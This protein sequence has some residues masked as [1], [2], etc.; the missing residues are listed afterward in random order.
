MLQATT[1][2]T[3]TSTKPASLIN[4]LRDSG[5]IKHYT[6]QDVHLKSGR[7]SNM[8]IDM[9][10]AFSSPQIVKTVCL[11]ME[12]LL[13]NYAIRARIPIQKLHLVGVPTAGVGWAKDLATHM[14]LPFKYVRKEAKSHGLRKLIEGGDIVVKD[15]EA[16]VL[17][18]DVCT[19]GTSVLEYVKLLRE[20][21]IPVAQVL[22]IADRGGL[23]NIREFVPTAESVLG[24]RDLFCGSP[25]DLLREIT[26][27]KQTKLIFSADITDPAELLSMVQKVAPSICA[28]KLHSDIVHNFN[29]TFIRELLALRD[30]HYFAIIEDAK[31]ADIASVTRTKFL[32]APQNPSGWA[33]FVTIHATS[34]LD[35][36]RAIIDLK[37]SGIIVISEMSTSAN[38]INENY[39]AAVY[40]MC[41]P[42][43]DSGYFGGFVAQG[44][45][46]PFSDFPRN[47]RSWHFFTPG[48]KLDQP[49]SS[50]SSGNSDSSSREGQNHRDPSKVG[51]DYHI[52]GR[53]IYLAQ[54]PSSE[55]MRYATM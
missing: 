27:M 26:E 28:L 51:T 24:F 11:E 55:A 43:Q 39:T 18:E 44:I 13:I 50:G 3:T 20:Y 15:G 14:R 47:G 40:E 8:Y 12:T 34:G 22:C 1:T 53:G 37:H 29:E 32:N 19:T 7:T 45:N 52:V 6:S 33:D 46:V 41:A 48:I 21:D 30:Q 17:I 23:R 9:R 31:Y 25:R 49:T 10:R 4:Q 2:T 42:L 16:V 5:C 54:D 38:L 36:L 35:A